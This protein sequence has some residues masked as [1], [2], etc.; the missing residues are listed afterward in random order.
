MLAHKQKKRVDKALKRLDAAIELLIFDLEDKG[1]LGPL[2]Q[3]RALSA[4][5]PDI[6]ALEDRLAWR[7]E[8]DADELLLLR[9]RI[10]KR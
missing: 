5:P 1:L 9:S 8:N 4:L 7:I 10:L 2:D 6:E 3:A